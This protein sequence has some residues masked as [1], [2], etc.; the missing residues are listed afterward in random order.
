MYAPSL[1]CRRVSR[2]P[3]GRWLR[4]A[5]H[6]RGY[7]TPVFSTGYIIPRV[8]TGVALVTVQ[9]ETHTVNTNTRHHP[10][11]ILALVG[12]FVLG[13]TATAIADD[14]DIIEEDDVS[15]S[16]STSRSG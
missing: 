8:G 14:D 4:T 6:V 12:L 5:V 15:L 1:L 11:T 3:G 2:P 7:A 13:L 9:G 10:L 16:E